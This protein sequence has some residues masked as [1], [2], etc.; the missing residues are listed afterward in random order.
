MFFSN[1]VSPNND[2]CDE[3]YAMPPL[4]GRKS[5]NHYT[6]EEVEAA[7]ILLALKSAPKCID[8]KE[9]KEV[10]VPRRSKR[11]QKKQRHDH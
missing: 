6:P 10:V 5:M 11:L 9:E 3:V 7:Y 8:A 4:R 2:I 1:V